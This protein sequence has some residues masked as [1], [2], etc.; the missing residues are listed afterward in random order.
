MIN[1]CIRHAMQ[2]L[3][4]D[5]SHCKTW[6]EFM[7]VQ[8]QRPSMSGEAVAMETDEV[9]RFTTQEGL[10]ESRYIELSPTGILRPLALHSNLKGELSVIE[11]SKTASLLM[12]DISLNLADG[13]DKVTDEIG[14]FYPSIGRVRVHA[15]QGRMANRLG[16]S[17]AMEK[18]QE[19]ASAKTQGRLTAC[20][21]L[22]I[23]ILAV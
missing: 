14:D 2:Q 6:T 10:H 11:I 23:I 22:G 4:L 19:G 20:L 7:K 16:K 1:A 8:Y 17:R 3:S 15:T 12:P 9:T 5:L 21:Q 13:P 18:G